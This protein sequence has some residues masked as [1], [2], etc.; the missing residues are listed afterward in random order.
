ML[1]RPISTLVISVALVLAVVIL[2]APYSPVAEAAQPRPCVQ[3]DRAGSA[4]FSPSDLP[5]TITRDDD[6]G[7]CHVM[8][9]V[10]VN[11][12]YARRI[13]A[14]KYGNST[15]K[16]TYNHRYAFTHAFAARSAADSAS[17]MAE[18]TQAT[19]AATLDEGQESI[20]E[21]MAEDAAVESQDLQDS[22]ATESEAEVA[23]MPTESAPTE[24]MTDTTTESNAVQPLVEQAV[25]DSKEI[26]EN[27]VGDIVETAAQDMHFATLLAAAGATGLSRTLRDA[28][29]YTVFAPNDEAFAAA[30]P[31]GDLDDLLIE[32]GDQLAQ[33]VRY[34]IVQDTYSTDALTDG[35]QLPTLQ[36]GVVTVTVEDGAFMIND[37]KIITPN[38]E[39]SNGVIHVIDGVLQPPTP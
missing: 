12:R 33:I 6:D 14:C 23:A 18:S 39:T 31:G 5:Q 11:G 3:I 26:P 8:S 24:V 4:S 29:P 1:R 16:D 38:I 37:A 21:V 27:E 9:F 17:Q 19:G 36:G 2:T 32:A 25:L 10:L 20:N 13:K 7:G 30:L 35:M 22:T 28:G 15:A 34:H